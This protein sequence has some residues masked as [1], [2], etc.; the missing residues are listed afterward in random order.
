MPKPVAKKTA[1]AQTINI[2]VPE[3]LRAGVYA[4]AVSVTINDN[5]VI[6]DLGYILPNVQPTTIEVVSR[7]NLSHR[8]AEQFVSILQ[9]SILD[10]RSRKQKA[11][12]A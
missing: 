2:N 1:P 9:N 10:Y 4:N 6:L 7:A 3:K 12:T 8:T 11:Q 5:E